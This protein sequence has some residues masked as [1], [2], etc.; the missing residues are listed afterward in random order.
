MT[1]VRCQGLCVREWIADGCDVRSVR[2]VRPSWWWRCINCGDR[3]DGT[4]LRHR[5][6]QEAVA[7]WAQEG[8]RRTTL[9]W[10]RLFAQLQRLGL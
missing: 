8:L 7:A 9:D 6:E 3:T 4:I 1:C 5:A 10:A 2:R